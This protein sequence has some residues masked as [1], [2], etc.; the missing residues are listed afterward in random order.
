[1]LACHKDE[2]R[3]PRSQA[4]RARPRC[5]GIWKNLYSRASRPAF[6]PHSDHASL[7]T[8][9][10]G[11]RI[12]H[13]GTGQL[14]RSAISSK[15]LIARAVLAFV[16]IILAACRSAPPPDAAYQEILE[17]SRRGDIEQALRHADLE[18]RRFAAKQPDQAWRFRVLKAQLLVLQGKSREALDLLNDEVP[19]S[20]SKTEVATRR[21]MVQ[22]LAHGFSQQFDQAEQD[23]D[24]AE[25]LARTLQPELQADILLSH[26]I[27]NTN[28][29]KYT[30]ADSRFRKALKIA[31]DW[32]LVS[33]QSRALGNLANVAMWQ[34]HYDEAVDWY[35]TS[36]Q[37]SESSGEK[38]TSAITFGNLGWSYSSMGDFENAL[39]YFEKAK[40]ASSKS[41]LS[42]GEVEWTIS[43]GN[44]YYEQH[45]YT[46]A[47]SAYRDALALARKL[48]FESPT[49][50]CLDDLAQI[51]LEKEDLDS[52]RSLSDQAIELT[53]NGKD[54]FL[55]PYSFLIQGRVEEAAKNYAKSER[56]LTTVIRD[57]NAGTSLQWEAKV[58]LAEVYASEGN[59][60]RADRQF[61]DAVQTV[62]TA[63]SSVKTEEFRLSFLS[64][65]IR[66]YGDYVDFLVGEG[67]TADALQVAELSRARTLA[68]G[69]GFSSAS[70]SFPIRGFQPTATARKL[71]ATILSY[72]LG[73][74]H[75]YAWVVTPRK[76]GSIPLPP[77]A[78]IDALVES[79]R[80]A[81]M[82]PRDALETANAAGQKLYEL[83]VAAP[84][85]QIPQG[86]RVI[87]IPDGSLYQLNFETL[88]VAQPRLHYWIDDVTVAKANSLVLLARSGHHRVTQKGKRLL[89]VG[90]PVPASNDF[91]KLRQA[92]LE[93]TQ[94]E[95]YFSASDRIVISGA[96]ATPQSYMDNHPGEFALVHF[97]A[98]GIASRTSP[99]DSAVIL[100]RQGDSYKLYARDIVKQPLRADLVTISACHGA[101]ERTYSGEG[102]VGLTWAFLRAGAHEVI[103]ALWEV[104]D[105]STTQ[106]MTRLYAGLSKG[107]SPESALRDAKLAL[108]HSGTVYKKPFYWAPF[109]IYRGP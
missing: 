21:K 72:W 83:L 54:H 33:V 42:S 90:D 52:A 13:G 18:Y 57:K 106:L 59:Q 11:R 65:G 88:L 12:R 62:E 81:L 86:S 34:E 96:S 3:L 37:V 49:A 41:G 9:F 55:T 32:N 20:L 71:N 40:D 101:G 47:E 44:T 30:E 45:D 7:R 51:A 28:E 8:G 10:T 2:S 36:L 56:L 14:Q 17:E 99:L 91:P 102:L 29:T 78:E 15:A 69:L 23:L 5:E 92:Q 68:D 100:T 98:H 108:L 25:D 31:R 95:N 38:D 73:T 24:E 39:A 64:S 1:L 19:L 35:K 76:I 46:S 50:E 105:N 22:G 66:V 53:R 70:L 4:G 82:G 103:S 104:D 58:H 63:R 84:S 6:L 27:V 109:E 80:Q 26:G 16:F 60:E 79:Y 97:V 107:A 75:S 87:V 94:I 74:K 43:V 67:R 77:A 85:K 48:G 61:R 93:M 89:L